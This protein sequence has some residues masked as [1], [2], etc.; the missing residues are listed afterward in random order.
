MV[1]HNHV[2]VHVAVREIVHEGDHEEDHEVVHEAVHVVDHE[3]DRE[4]PVDVDRDVDE[5]VLAERMQDSH[6]VLGHPVVLEEDLVVVHHVLEAVRL[7]H[8]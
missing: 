4:V 2:V 6:E 7:D 3:V 5:V 1:A 8:P